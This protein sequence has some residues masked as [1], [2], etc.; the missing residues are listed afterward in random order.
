[1]QKRIPTK[2]FWVRITVRYLSHTQ[3]IVASEKYLEPTPHKTEIGYGTGP[4]KSLH[5]VVTGTTTHP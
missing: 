3:R 4:I 5:L 2:D 1:M